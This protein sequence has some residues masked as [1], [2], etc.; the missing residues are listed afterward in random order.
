MARYIMIKLKENIFDEQLQN[1]LDKIDTIE[2]V[3]DIFLYN[4]A[5]EISP[6]WVS[7]TEKGTLKCRGCPNS[8]LVYGKYWWCDE[9]RMKVDADDS[10]Q[11]CI[12]EGKTGEYEDW[13]QERE[14]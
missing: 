2:E 11:R 9:L 6:A 8:R 7:V 1:I 4:K 13:F 10:C 12:E 3:Q 14:N 5:E